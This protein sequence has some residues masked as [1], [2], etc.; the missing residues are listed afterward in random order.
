[1]EWW[2][3]FDFVLSRS[4]RALRVESV[5]MTTQPEWPPPL[6]VLFMTTQPEWPPPLPLRFKTTLKEWQTT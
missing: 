6:P 1:M 5:Y 4:K 2:G 3:S